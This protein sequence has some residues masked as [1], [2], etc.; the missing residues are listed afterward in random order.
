MGRHSIPWNWPQNSSPSHP[1]VC[2]SCRTDVC[3][4]S[5]APRCNFAWCIQISIL[6]TS[7]PR[8]AIVLPRFSPARCSL[9]GSLV[10]SPI[11]ERS[12]S[13]SS[14]KSFFVSSNRGD[15]IRTCDLLVPDHQLSNLPI[16]AAVIRLFSP[17]LKPLGPTPCRAIQSIL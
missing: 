15:R 14:P 16:A 17:R 10:S 9:A 6:D 5:S 7:Q 13:T 11:N 8:A 12:P 3:G 2:I 4:N 1:G